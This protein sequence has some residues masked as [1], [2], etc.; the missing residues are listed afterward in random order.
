M[1]STWNFLR[2]S[3]PRAHFNQ[4]VMGMFMPSQSH[5][6]GVSLNLYIGNITQELQFLT[7]GKKTK[8]ILRLACHRQPSNK[9][10][11]VN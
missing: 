6:G 4:V 3:L 1:E 9:H 8:L 2:C 5:S 11:E 10:N 7:G